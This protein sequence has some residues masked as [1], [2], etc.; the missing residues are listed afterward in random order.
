MKVVDETLQVTSDQMTRKRRNGRHGAAKEQRRPV[1]LQFGTDPSR[2]L[3]KL[4]T[5]KII[6]NKNTRYK[7]VNK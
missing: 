1:R 6:K 3:Q 2:S 4:I 7:L 5:L